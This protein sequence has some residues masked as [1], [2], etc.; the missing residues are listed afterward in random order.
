MK[1]IDLF[2]GCGGMTAGFVNAGWTPVWAV[3][4]MKAP[5]RTYGE[6]F[7]DRHQCNVF[8]GKIQDFAK[9]LQSGT[10]KVPKVDAVI[11]GPP[12]QGHSPLGKM[13]AKKERR[14]EH[15]DLNNLWK[16]LVVVVEIT[17]PNYVLIENVPQFFKHQ[18]FKKC[19][20]ALADV[21]YPFPDYGILKAEEFG[22]PQKR[23]R[24]FIIAAKN[25]IITL[26]LPNG[27]RKT[28]F[29]AIGHL[30]KKPDGRNWHIGRNPTKLSVERY[31][32]IPEGGNRFDLMRKRPDITPRCWLDKL[33]GTTDV[34]GRLEWDGMATTIRAEFFKPEKGRYLH[35]KEHRAITHREAALLQTFDEDFSF[36]GSKT[37]VARQIGE[38]VPPKLAKVFARHFESHASDLL[39]ESHLF[40]VAAE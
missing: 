31:K 20:R 6:N 10:L 18:S 14:Q 8:N 39:Q 28:V 24:G 3:E 23:R 2:S 36:S 15:K 7:A 16:H 29:D 21:G 30:P 25:S 27:E 1:F 9:F 38:A 17:K 13:S 12:C 26:P 32:V 22:V 35:P 40:C 11:G 37:E 5:A 33:I 19:L 4:L 34:F